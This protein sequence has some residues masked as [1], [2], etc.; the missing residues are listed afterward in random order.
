MSDPT[1]LLALAERCEQAA[2]PDREL[3][4]EIALAAGWERKWNDSDK[5]HGWYWRRGD[6]SWTAEMEGIPPN[7]TASLDAAVTLVPEGCGWMV[8][9]NAAKVGRW[10]SR[11]ATPAL[12]LCAAALRARAAAA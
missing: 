9:G 4:A 10:P 1:T 6:Y 8:M 11:G 3:D 2:G 7:Y 12:A 5:P